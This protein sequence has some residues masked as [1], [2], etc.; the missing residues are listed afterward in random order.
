MPA[1]ATDPVIPIKPLELVEGQYDQFIGI[2]DNHVPK[3]L[4][5]KLIDLSNK[6]LD[7]DATSG[8]NDVESEESIIMDGNRQF[9]QGSLGRK[10]QSILVQ[11]ADGMLHAELNQYLTAAFLHYITEY[12]MKQQFKLL[13]YDQKLQRTQPG[14]G[15]HVWHAENTTY[16]MTHRE[17]VWMVYLNDDF[18]GGETEFL[19]QHKRL[20][21][22]RGTVVIW[23]AAWP[24]QHRGNPPLEGT[25]Y[26]LT[27]WYI[28]CP[29]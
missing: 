12:G 4:C 2:Y 15:Y 17:L 19:H 5:D 8:S 13:S 6:S 21:P 22:K 29:V 11:Y 3:F 10:D 20:T 9:A 23:P 24:W 16:E 26:I 7:T 1:R 25:K 28:N 18:T 14:G 27:G